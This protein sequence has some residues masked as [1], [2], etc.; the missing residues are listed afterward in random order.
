M[1]EERHMSFHYIYNDQ[2]SYFMNHCHRT[3]KQTLTRVQQH[4]QTVAVKT[5]LI[6]D[7]WRAEHIHR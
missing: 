4:R 2:L 1:K 3:R 5:I 6:K 7:G